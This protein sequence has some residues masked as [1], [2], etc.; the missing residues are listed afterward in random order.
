MQSLAQGWWCPREGEGRWLHHKAFINSP[1]S[2]LHSLLFTYSHNLKSFS[3]SL[4]SFKFLQQTL[5]LHSPISWPHHPT[6]PFDH[7]SS[8]PTFPTTEPLFSLILTTRLP[9]F[10]HCLEVSFIKPTYHQFLTW[11]S[12]NPEFPNCFYPWNFKKPNPI[13][14]ITLQSVMEATYLRHPEN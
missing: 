7:P 11:C 8:D 3:P 12:S 10:L 6:L 14:P 1:S 13:N 5:N 9:W 2:S 4:F